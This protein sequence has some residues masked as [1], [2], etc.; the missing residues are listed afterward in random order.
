MNQRLPSGPAAI[1]VVL[2]PGVIPAEYSVTVPAGVIRPIPI[3]STPLK[4][5]V[6]QRLP[7]GPAAMSY[8]VLSGVI[9]SENSVTAPSGAADALAVPASRA[10]EDTTS[11]AAQTDRA[12]SAADGKHRGTTTSRAQRMS[13][14]SMDPQWLPA[15]TP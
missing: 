6:N 4:Y 12:R 11:A 10:R 5:S 9:P 14:P 13:T 8:G 2:L 15:G 7:S 1:P 3:P